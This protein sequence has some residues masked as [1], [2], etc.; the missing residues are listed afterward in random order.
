MEKHFNCFFVNNKEI[1]METISRKWSSF[2]AC[3]FSS[4][5]SLLSHG[6]TI[7]VFFH[8]WKERKVSSVTSWVASDNSVIDRRYLFLRA[9]TLKEFFFKSNINLYLLTYARVGQSATRGL[10]LAHWVP[11]CSPWGSFFH[12]VS[13]YGM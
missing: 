6:V 5:L 1:I 4:F 8:A 13:L 3:F 10:N 11:L 7:K 12:T 9:P 2:C